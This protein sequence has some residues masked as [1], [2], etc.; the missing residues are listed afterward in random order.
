MQ[1]L[2]SCSVAELITEGSGCN[3]RLIAHAGGKH[4]SISRRYPGPVMIAIGPEGGFTPTE[5]AA[6]AK[7]DWNVVDLGP[8][9]MRVETAA[10][11]LVS[12]VAA[13]QLF[14]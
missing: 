1:I 2:P 12:Q 8:R 14:D 11:A 9:I 5:V 13:T 6:A 10:L 3:T 7:A 4:L